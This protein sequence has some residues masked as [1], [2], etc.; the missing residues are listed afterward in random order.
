MDATKGI[1]NGVLIGLCFWFIVFL[2][3]GCGPPQYIAQKI[4]Y[5][6]TFYLYNDPIKL[7]AEYVKSNGTQNDV[8]GF[9]RMEDNSIH[10]MK[11]DLEVMGHEL[12]HG[13]RT[14]GLI[15][16]DDFHEHFK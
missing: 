7:D 5:C 3:V 8:I 15:I 16:E 6:G 4:D 10:V 13:L 9:Y 2:F 12:Y 11:W 14:K 1:I